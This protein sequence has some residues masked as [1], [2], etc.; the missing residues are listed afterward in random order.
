MQKTL[1]NTRL[2]DYFL[3]H[4]GVLVVSFTGIFGKAIHLREIVLVWY[5]LLL[6]VVFLGLFVWL[7]GNFQKIPR[8]VMIKA[9]AAGCLMATHWVLWYGSIKVSNSSIAMSTI[10][11][12]AVFT[13]LMEPLIEKTKYRLL[14]VSLAFLSGLGML[15]VF[16]GQSNSLGLIM[17]IVSAFVV[18]IA[19]IFNRG[20]TQSYNNVFML[21]LFEFFVAWIFLCLLMPFYLHIFPGTDLLPDKNDWL[22]LLVFVIVCTLFP[23]LLNL[24]LMRNITALTSSMAYNMEPVW[25][26][27]LAI[28]IYHEQKELNARFFIGTAI[29]T[30][31]VMAYFYIRFRRKQASVSA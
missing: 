18:S 11:M 31:S 21:T 2:K 6:A 20:L 14:E 3:L 15:V 26:I 13:A 17:G 10:S 24:Y 22:L 27:L 29:V 7:S 25:G 8:K 30:L 16:S 23:F 9:A 5:R 1:A 28:L 4:F 12:V 19:A